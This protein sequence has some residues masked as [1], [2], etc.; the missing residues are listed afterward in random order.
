MSQEIYAAKSSG[1]SG[2]LKSIVITGLIAGT[3]DAAAAIIVS[4]ATPLQVFRYIASAVFGRAAF[5]GGL[6]MGFWGLLFHYMIAFSWTILFFVL[7]PKVVLLRK[8]KYVVGVL[9]GIFVWAVMNMVIV[10]MTKIPGR[11]MTFT[12]AITQCTILILMI[13]L[14]ISLLAHRYYSRR[15]R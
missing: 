6:V 14:P 8:N 12:G 9:C 5:S 1:R 3:L 2:L 15:S 10:P 7:Y 4:G 13:G 11:A